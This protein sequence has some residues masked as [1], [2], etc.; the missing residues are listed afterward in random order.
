MSSPLR[1]NSRERGRSSSSSNSRDKFNN[2]SY[3]RS[4]SPLL[5][6]QQRLPSSSRAELPSPSPVNS[7]PSRRSSYIS[8]PLFPGTRGSNTAGPLLGLTP[9]QVSI[10]SPGPGYGPSASFFLPPPVTSFAYAQ[11]KSVYDMQRSPIY[12]LQQQVKALTTELQELLDA[13][14]TGLLMNSAAEA[15]DT[16]KG[17]GEASMNGRSA[18]DGGVTSSVMSNRPKGPKISLK[19][20]RQGIIRAMKALAEVKSMEEEVY[21][22]EEAERSKNI[23]QVE[24]WESKRTELETGIKEV[25][26]GEEAR[27]IVELRKEREDVEVYSAIN[28][29]PWNLI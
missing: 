14:S 28:R 19:A 17:N 24:E 1:F 13:Q 16:E 29:F 6:S 7:P 4:Y 2:D 26:Q 15:P 27:R 25:E 11:T 12:T 23:N 5:A 18:W 3:S 8:S 21:A 9:T 20:A 22:V 10:Q